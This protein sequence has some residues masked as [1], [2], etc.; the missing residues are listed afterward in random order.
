MLQPLR[1]LPESSSQPFD[2][3]SRGRNCSDRK[4]VL[5][6]QPRRRPVSVIADG[7]LAC[8]ADKA[9]PLHPSATCSDRFSPSSVDFDPP[10]RWNHSI[11]RVALGLQ[12]RLTVPPLVDNS[13]AG[14]TH[15]LAA[16]GIIDSFGPM[17]VVHAANPW[18][19]VV[20]SELFSIDHA[21]R[22]FCG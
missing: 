15:R 14:R 1:V 12:H 20:D 2:E 5:T 7:W 11:Y 9:P 8:D 17:P 13:S 18:P 10:Y 22:F 16:G 6:D 21:R 19:F 3:K 4:P